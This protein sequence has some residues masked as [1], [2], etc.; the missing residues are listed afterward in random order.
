MSEHLAKE[1]ILKYNDFGDNML[2]LVKDLIEFKTVNSEEEF[3]KCFNY[4]KDYLK[5][6]NLFIKEYSFNNKRSLVISNTQDKELDVIFCGHLDVVPGNTSQFNPVLKNDLLYG[7]GSYDMKGHDAVMIKLMKNLDTKRKIAL[8][9]TTDEEQGGFNGTNKLLNEEGYSCNL[10]IVPDAGNNFDLIIEEKAVLQLELSIKG[11]PAHASTPWKGVN[12]ITEL[13]NVYYKLL[14]IYPLPKNENEFIT[15]IN[16]GY[17]NGGDAINRVPSKALIG[18]DIR[19]VNSDSKEEIIDNIKRISKNVD[20]KVL[21]TGIKFLY[22]EN[23]LSKKFINVSEKVLKRKINFN[24]CEGSSDARFF[25]EK[26][27]SCILMNAKGFDMHGDNEYIDI[28]SLEK[29]YQ[30]YLDF[31]KTL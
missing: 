30:I 24:T 22:L 17:I 13:M 2:K 7:R 20:V 14:E 9:L 10:A 23:E 11:I 1:K 19:Y 31:I 8:F 18:L 28:T 12:A 26:G 3:N 29:L 4:I 5:E 6:T 16:L 27:I 21:E 25:Y 15:S